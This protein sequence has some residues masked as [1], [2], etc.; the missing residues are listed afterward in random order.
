MRASLGLKVRCMQFNIIAGSHNYNGGTRA[1]PLQ[2][3]SHHL[4]ISSPMDKNCVIKAGV[5][6]VMGGAMGLIM[7]MFMN[8]VEMR[9]I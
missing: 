2:Y 8:A 3:A 1:Q 9:E 7:A 5:S 4:E 6:Y